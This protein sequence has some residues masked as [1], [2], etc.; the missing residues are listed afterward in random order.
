MLFTP[1]SRIQAYDYRNV[2]EIQLYN[3]ISVTVWYSI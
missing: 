2:M 1:E 3:N